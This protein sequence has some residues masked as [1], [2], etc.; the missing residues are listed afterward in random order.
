M[1]SS[2]AKPADP[3]AAPAAAK[4]TI[5]A[6]Y[7]FGKFRSRW[8][9]LIAMI[10][11]YDVLAIPFMICFHVGDDIPTLV[12]NAFLDSLLIADVV[13]QTYFPFEMDGLVIHGRKHIIR[14]YFSTWMIPDILASIPFDVL[15]AI[16]SVGIN[17]L[18][19]INKLIRMFR[20]SYYSELLEKHSRLN[21]SVV[22]ILKFTMVVLL[23]SHYVACGWFLVIYIEGS[24]VSQQWTSDPGF[25]QKPVYYQYLVSFYWSL[26][27]MTGYGGPLPIT[28]LE[29]TYTLF[30]VIIGVAVYVTIIGTVGSLV[31]NLDSSASAFRQKMD[32]INDYMKYRR[33]PLDLQNR[34]RSYYTYLWKSR[35]GLDETQVLE[36]LPSY[37]RMEVA[38]FLNR[39]IIQKVPLF[40]GADPQFISTIVMSM[41]PRV[42]LPNSYI[43]KKGEVGKE[44][45]FISRGEVEVVSEDGAVVYARLKEGSFFGEIALVTS[46]KRTA[47]VRAATYCDLFVLMKEDFDE[48]L[49][50]FPEQA[51]AILQAAEARYNLIKKTSTSDDKA[52]PPV[53]APSSSGSSSSIKEDAAPKLP[54]SSSSSSVKSE[55]SAPPPSAGAAAANGGSA[56][57]GGGDGGD[58]SGTAAAAVVEKK[59]SSS[60]IRTSDESNQPPK[61]SVP[62]AMPDTSSSSFTA[63][64]TSASSSSSSSPPPPPPPSLQPAPEPSSEQPVAAGPASAG[65]QQASAEPSS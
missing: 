47:S 46:G 40:Q 6:L 34:V 64:S 60:A 62:P 61:Q 21:P 12:V 15:Q 27:T 10:V 3:K 53:A 22:R 32:T 23:V 33:L 42:S 58:E 36:D 45:F 18:T 54:Q 26:V 52:K 31:T 13:L 20:L 51:K 2:A 59:D 7:E 16:P 5:S 4:T 25:L 55:S 19:R 41:R 48:V 24:A 39:E 9:F 50:D 43:I 37:L 17:P 44:M 35:K 63:V 29:T 1:S 30:V 8:T 56:N 38:L 28:D 49:A 14:N 57:G 11:L 65:S